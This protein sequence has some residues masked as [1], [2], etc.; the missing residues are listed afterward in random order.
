MS[1]KTENY[2]LL[3]ENWIPVLWNNGTY[4]RI[5]ILDALTK[6]RRIR[7]IAAS[8]PMD[9][10]AIIRFLLALL[11]WCKGNPTENS[12][13]NYGNSFPEEWFTKLNDHKDCFNLLGEGKRFYQVCYAKRIRAATDLIQEI[14]TGNNF[15]HTRHSTDNIDGLCSSCCAMGLLRLPLFSVS[16]LP[17]L[18]AGIN[19]TPPIYIIPYGISLFETLQANW[20]QNNL[21]GQPSW[22]QPDIQLSQEEDVPIL[23]GLTL[24]SRLVWLHDP[25]EPSGIC[26]GCGTRKNKLIRTCMFQSAGEQ[27]NDRWNDPHVFYLDISP[28]KALKANDPTASG[29]FRMDKP[30]NDIFIN[31]INYGMIRFKNNQ[32]YFHVVG[33]ATDK[34]K[35]IDVWERIIYMPLKE[36]IQNLSDN[37]IYQ[38]WK[39]GGKI[40]RKIAKI[41]RSR[42]ESTAII[43]MIRPQIENNVSVK[44]EKLI[45]STESEWEKASVE[46]RPMMSAVAKSLSPGFTTEALQ[47]R[48]QIAFITPNMRTQTKSDEKNPQKNGD[49]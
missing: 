32:K 5:G 7:Q 33:F 19:G 30:W 41:V 13:S 28:R 2:N 48:Q 22:L 1:K 31:L 29:K 23:T 49:E 39:E 44:L 46:Y 42:K 43:S 18:K 24:L 9:R 36:S 17:D 21:F 47:R 12:E 37:Q 40:D 27:K 38:W 34:A 45:T 15:W 4:E 25:I 14:P 26:M 10:V 6:S 11:Y 35:N 3:V 20:L 16:G 8:N